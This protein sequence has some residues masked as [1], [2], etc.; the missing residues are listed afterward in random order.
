M[1]KKLE[2]FAIVKNGIGIGM[3]NLVPI[4]VNVL[5]WILTVWI[6]YLNI[7]TTIGLAV[8][9]I[10]KASKGEPISMT[11]IFDPKYRKFMGEFFLSQG[12]V[13][14]GA[15]VG[16]A[17]LIIPGIVISIAWSFATLLTVDKGKNPTEALT[18][19]N[20]ATYGNKGP[21]FLAYL[22]LMVAACIAGALVSLIPVLGVI[23]LIALFVFVMFTCIG[24]QAFCYKELCQNS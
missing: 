13:A 2:V 22:A 15:G 18:I 5:L 20:N 11:E 12:L 3:N 14:I 17:L 7:G 6:P 24:I 8:G 10:S 21:M 23:L 19:S 4:L 16:C 1:E 9:I